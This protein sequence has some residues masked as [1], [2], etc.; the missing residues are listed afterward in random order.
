MTRAGL[1]APEAAEQA[2]LMEMGM[3]V[4]TEVHQPVLADKETVHLAGQ[5]E[6]EARITAALEGM[7]LNGAHTVPEEAVVE[8]EKM[9]VSS[10]LET[11][12]TAE[13][14]EPEAEATEALPARLRLTVATALPASSSSLIR[15][16]L[17]I[18]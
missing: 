2:G 1:M 18:A 10:R 3:Q 17:Q 11:E 8:E 13:L 16:L 6:A 4:L 9:A 14:T 5:E 12:A 15:R 7:G